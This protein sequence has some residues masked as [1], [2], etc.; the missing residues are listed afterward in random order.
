MGV[1]EL[2]EVREEL[3]KILSNDLFSGTG[4]IE[5]GI[6]EAEGSRFNIGDRE[7]K[8]EIKISRILETHSLI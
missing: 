5:G 6:S 1:E 8:R 7:L 2:E 4:I 3:G